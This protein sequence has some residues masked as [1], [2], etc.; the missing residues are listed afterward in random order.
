[1]KKIVSDS[2][3]TDRIH[4][5][6]FWRSRKSRNEFVQRLENAKRS[7]NFQARIAKTQ[8]VVNSRM[9]HVCYIKCT[10]VTIEQGFRLVRGVDERMFNEIK[11]R[12]PQV[13]S[14]PSYH[15]LAKLFVSRKACYR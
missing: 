12:K 4:D 1:M 8:S 13:V 11:I 7:Q 5:A 6:L 14:L 9:P 15:P 3:L 2:H 10:E